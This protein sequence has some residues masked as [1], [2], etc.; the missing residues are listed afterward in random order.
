MAGWL[1]FVPGFGITYKETPPYWTSNVMLTY[2]LIM[3]VHHGHL[4]L[5]QPARHPFHIRSHMP[6]NPDTTFARASTETHNHGM[7]STTP[8]H[9]V[10]TLSEADFHPHLSTPL[11]T[12]STVNPISP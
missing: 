1:T 10:N 3:T 5:V 11:R 4:H 6:I 8:H 9:L 7:A 12:S 2:S